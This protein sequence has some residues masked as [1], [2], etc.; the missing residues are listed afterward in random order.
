M[1]YT[2]IERLEELELHYNRQSSTPPEIINASANMHVQ[3]DPKNLDFTIFFIT[4]K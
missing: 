4:H 3:R 2:T 1:N